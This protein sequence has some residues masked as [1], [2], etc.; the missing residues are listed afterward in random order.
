MAKL[1]SLIS[2][3]NMLF[4]TGYAANLGVLSALLAPGDAVLLD[5]DA[6]A[7]LYDGCKMSGADVFRFKHNDMNSLERRLEHLGANDG[8]L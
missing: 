3:E 8:N 2:S 6:H 4:S 5:A 7:S 1:N